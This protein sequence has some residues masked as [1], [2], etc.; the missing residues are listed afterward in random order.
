M[1]TSQIERFFIIS[2]N[3]LS[4]KKKYVK[5]I[6]RWSAIKLTP[7]IHLIGCSRGCYFSFKLNLNY[8]SP[9]DVFIPLHTRKLVLLLLLS[10]MLLI[11]NLTWKFKLKNVYDCESHSVFSSSIACYVS[12]HRQFISSFYSSEHNVYVR[13]GT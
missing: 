3:N 8:K 11:R 12:A 6:F 4:T 13:G 10:T 5:L 9:E 7:C 1:S 2:R